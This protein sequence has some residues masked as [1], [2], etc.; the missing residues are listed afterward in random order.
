MTAT[1]LSSTGKITRAELQQIPVPEATRTHQPLPHYRVVE[2]LIET[3]GFRHIQVVRDEYA[4]SSDGMKMFGVMD[5]E[6]GITGVNFSIGLRNSNDKSLRLALTVGYRVLLCDNLAFVGDFTPLL[7]K[8][9]KHFSLIDAV[10]VGVDRM[11][12]NF[13]PLARQIGEW[14]EREITD[15]LAKLVIYRAFIE[16]E[17]QVPKHLAGIVHR[18]YFQP[19]CE[20]FTPRSFWSLSNA[21]TAALKELDAIPQFRATAKLGPF[22]A[23]QYGTN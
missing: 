4:V 6:Y 23:R 9:S 17:L 2:A 12:R 11:Q 16:G 3:L 10:S 5:L 1:L 8:H 18:E 13:E 15:E 7:A 22:L 21:F 20:E 19:D 14:R